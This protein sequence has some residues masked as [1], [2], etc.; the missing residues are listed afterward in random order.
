VS[1]PSLPPCFHHP[2]ESP[3]ITVFS[4]ILSLPNHEVGYHDSSLMEYDVF[5]RYACHAVTRCTVTYLC[6]ATRAPPC[7]RTDGQKRNV[8]RSIT[9]TAARAPAL[10]VANGCR[11]LRHKRLH[12]CSLLFWQWRW[13]SLRLS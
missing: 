11:R 8:A 13:L 9:T 10:P 2:N 1:H 4:S 6:P 7:I 12:T 3:H 5:C